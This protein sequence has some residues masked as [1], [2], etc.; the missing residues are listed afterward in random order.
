[1]SFSSRSFIDTR[2][3]R[4]HIHYFL[5]VIHQPE[6]LPRGSSFK[7]AQCQAAL[8]RKKGGDQKTSSFTRSKGPF[9]HSLTL[10]NSGPIC[11]KLDKKLVMAVSTL[12]STSFSKTAAA[13]G[14]VL[15]FSLAILG[16]IRLKPSHST[17]YGLT[18]PGDRILEH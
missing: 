3:S 1:M 11:D 4:L 12:R 18:G 14:Y 10:N 13:P 6:Q 8:C 16:Y 5:L 15:N 17:S 9:T 7:E 2:R